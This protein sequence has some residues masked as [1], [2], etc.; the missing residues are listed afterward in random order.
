MLDMPSFIIK[1]RFDNIIIKTANL[2]INLKS[3]LTEI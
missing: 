3:T 1:N 2:L